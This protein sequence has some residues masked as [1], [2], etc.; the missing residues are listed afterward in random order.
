MGDIDG[1]RLD[2]RMTCPMPD[3]SVILYGVKSRMSLSKL[4]SGLI[5]IDV[6]RMCSLNRVQPASRQRSVM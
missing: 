5:G 4:P 2:R 1:A 6:N 3:N